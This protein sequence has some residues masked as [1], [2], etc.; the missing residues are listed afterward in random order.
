MR[1]DIPISVIMPVRQGELFIAEAI[2]S[3]LNQTF[4]C[5]ELIVIDDGSTDGTEE[6]IRGFKDFRILY[7]KV[8]YSNNYQSR[9]LGMSLSKGKYICMMDSDDIAYPNRL[10]R[11]YDYLETHKHVSILGTQMT[12]IDQR[13]LRIS[14]SEWRPLNHSKIKIWQ[15]MN[16]YIAQPTLMFRSNIFKGHKLMYD[17]NFVFSGDYEFMVRL[18]HRFKTANLKIPLV[19]YRKH[20]GQISMKKSD[21]QGMFADR[22]RMKQLEAFDL[23]ISTNEKMLHLNMM[24]C[25]YL[26]NEHLPLAEKWLN[27]LLTANQE[28]K[29]YNSNELY[30]FFE[31]VLTIA[32]KQN[33][34]GGWAIEK[35]FLN[36]VEKNFEKKS[37]ILEFG[38]G[39][40][41]EA[42][43]ENYEV[44]S[45]EHN[46]E[47]FVNRGKGHNI[48]LAPIVDGWYSSKVVEEKLRESY[49]LIIIDGPPRELRKGILK[50]INLFKNVSIPIIFDDMDRDFDRNIM[51]SFCKSL[52]YE[53]ELFKGN[54]KLFAVC[55]KSL[56]KSRLDLA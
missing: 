18:C 11:Q 53:Y 31:L 17:T 50:N 45:I 46:E 40:G 29:I 25:N 30:N 21:E 15:L 20:S 32:V 6:I 38:S 39:N 16:I 56:A 13:G 14:S 51:E 44:T 12:L 26:K 36:Y 19:K 41:T 23:E 9:N 48:I 10:E 7:R 5:F 2:K 55:C 35:E 3:I 47:F 1:Y 52:G 27:K 49:K 43:L 4:D 54:L 8:N 37:R 24:K 22:V 34:L 28:N 42:L 33:K